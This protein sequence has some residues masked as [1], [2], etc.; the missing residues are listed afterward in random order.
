MI[1]PSCLAGLMTL[2]GLS[3]LLA[4]PLLPAWVRTVTVSSIASPA[5]GEGTSADAG[6]KENGLF[7][8]LPSRQMLFIRTVDNCGD[9]G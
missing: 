7:I 2:I 8:V 6:Q 4:T 3:H 5:D 9:S 1:L